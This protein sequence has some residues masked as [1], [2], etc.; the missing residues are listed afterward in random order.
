MMPKTGEKFSVAYESDYW[1]YKNR[2]RMVS[3]PHAAMLAITGTYNSWMLSAAKDV[4]EEMAIGMN[5][6]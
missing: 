1:A 5:D 6:T 4:F 2:P 3:S